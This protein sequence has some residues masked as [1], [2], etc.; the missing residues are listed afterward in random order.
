M[1]LP[2]KISV[3]QLEED[4]PQR[5]YFRL[6]P[7]LVNDGAGFTRA[8]IAN[9]Q[10]P[11]EGYIRVVPDKN[12]AIRFKNRMRGMG[13]YCVMDLSRFP[14][15]AEKIR[16]NKNYNPENGEINRLIVY[17]DVISA[18][19]EYK[20]MQAVEPISSPDRTATLRQG[21]K[22]YTPRVLLIE[23]EM[24]KG[25]FIPEP[26]RN[27]GEWALAQDLSAEKI[28]LPVQEL[29][30]LPRD[31]REV[32]LY[33]SPA[34]FTAKEPDASPAPENVPAGEKAPAGEKT[35]ASNGEAK[36]AEA[37]AETAPSAPVRSEEEHH[38]RRKGESLAGQT[39][40]NPRRGRSIFEIVDEQWKQS[41]VERLGASVS[42]SASLNAAVSPVDKAINALREALELKDA[43]AALSRGLNS[44]PGLKDILELPCAPS[45]NAGGPRDGVLDELEGERLRLLNEI[46]KLKSQKLQKQ[47]EI[48]EET[49][50]AHKLEF[51]RLEK[52]TARLDQ[53]KEIR[54]RAAE[55]ARQAQR[56]A[57]RL[58]SGESQ[59]RL[60]G[61]FLKF[62]MFSR[63]AGLIRDGV[64]APEGTFT[65]VPKT[66]DFTPAQLISDLR[67]HFE[68]MGMCLTNDEALSL[69]VALNVGSIVL[70]SGEPGCGKSAFTDALADVL[71]LTQE[72]AERYVKIDAGSSDV[73]KNAAFNALMLSD[74]RLTPRLVAIE[75]INMFSGGDQSRG[76]M[77]SAF[78]LKSRGVTVLMTCQDAGY[79]YPLD[80][81]LLDR[82]FFLRLKPYR[83]SKWERQSLPRTAS[84]APRLDAFGKM[85]SSSGE[86]CGENALRM[87]K[88]INELSAGGARLSRRMLAETYEFCAAMEA[89]MAGDKKEA[90]DRAI[91]MRA[92]PAV[93]ASAP[94]KLI[95]E[96]PGLL[97]DMPLSISLLNVPI[98]MTEI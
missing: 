44:L 39:G 61:E 72:G 9:D 77:D 53:E 50:L 4:N 10:F 87:E 88:L 66:Q 40:L 56:E 79:G 96:L 12:E 2:G 47:G 46:D 19:G 22:V 6:R 57:E 84:C 41:R 98:A 80:P 7:V 58:L 90:L 23:G 34:L 42:D 31:G 13:G 75:D 5:A 94:A 83:P 67:S 30:R 69:L 74:D 28:D 81:R 14:G 16:P 15:E 60:D 25:P 63:A 8:D 76:M 65:G 64:Q 36:P 17:S 43:S 86:V 26:G 48:M 95:R 29:I 33:V 49:R 59:A 38:R 21:E 82:A 73:R 85:F 51:D 35:P 55:S 68:K 78:R 97:W 70:V 3:C 45:P 24:A 18:C 91:A 32:L 93:L 71:G 89:L 92:L 52:E 1:T 37:K 27:L 62:A 20:L 54:L 11:D